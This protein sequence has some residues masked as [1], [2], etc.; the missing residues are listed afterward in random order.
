MLLMFYPIL[1][2][3]CPQRHNFGT[4]THVNVPVYPCEGCEGLFLLLFFNG[5]LR[6]SEMKTR[7]YVGTRALTFTLMPITIMQLGRWFILESHFRGG[8]LSR[9]QSHKQAHAR[10][11]FQYGRQ[12][13]KKKKKY[14][15][16]LFQFSSILFSFFP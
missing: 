1:S 5:R 16:H 10:A 12:S 9:L 8:F 15:G 6:V 11:P 7:L 2:T 14:T 4:Q 13:E 3:R